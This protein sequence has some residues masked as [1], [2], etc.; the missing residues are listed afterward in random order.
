MKG[1]VCRRSKIE[2]GLSAARDL[3]RNL[4]LVEIE[5]RRVGSFGC[6]AAQGAE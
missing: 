6:L 2:G 4:L 5:V 3:K 1:E